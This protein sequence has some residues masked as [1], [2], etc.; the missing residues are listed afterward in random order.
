MVVDVLLGHNCGW[1]ISL[2]VSEKAVV[3]SLLL[4]SLEALVTGGVYSKRASILGVPT[5]KLFRG[6]RMVAQHGTNRW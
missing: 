2:W 4:T 6:C 1:R 3:A 5:R